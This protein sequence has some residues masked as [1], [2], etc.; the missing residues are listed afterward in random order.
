MAR[1]PPP[2]RNAGWAAAA[3]F[4][5]IPTHKNRANHISRYL[6]PKRGPH[7]R[8]YTCSHLKAARTKAAPPEVTGSP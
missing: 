1:Q 7:R 2:G 3:G 4:P 6:L 5:V 8:R